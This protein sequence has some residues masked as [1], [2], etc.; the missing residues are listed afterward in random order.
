MTGAP[1]HAA[2]ADRRP[3]ERLVAAGVVLFVLGTVAVLVAVVPVL[4]GAEQSRDLPALLSGVLLPLGL[5]VALVGLL[6]GARARRRAARRSS[7][8]T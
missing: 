2:A 3:G 5:A 7:T 4:L 1:R 6:R 8:P